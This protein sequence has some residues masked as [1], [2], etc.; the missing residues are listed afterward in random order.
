MTFNNFQLFFPTTLRTTPLVLDALVKQRAVIFP[1]AGELDIAERANAAFAIAQ[2]SFVMTE[3]EEIAAAAAGGASEL[4]PTLALDLP[5]DR[6]DGLAGL[7]I[8]SR[9]GSMYSSSD[10]ASR[11]T[12]N[13]DR[14]DK[15]AKSAGS[16]FKDGYRVN[17][18]NSAALLSRRASTHMVDL[19]APGAYTDDA[20]S[21]DEA[22]KVAFPKMAKVEEPLQTDSWSATPIAAMFHRRS[23]SAGDLL[24]RS[25]NS[26]DQPIAEQEWGTLLSTSYYPRCVSAMVELIVDGWCRSAE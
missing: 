23:T 7:T 12:I 13:G 19:P 3:P 10:N 9:P 24:T 16:S 4:S 8:A 6:L 11:I 21:S 14:V 5:S 1:A 17:K 2:A 18:R 25:A 20:S 22:G 15:S 26:V